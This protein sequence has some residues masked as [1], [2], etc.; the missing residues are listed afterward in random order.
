MK[1]EILYDLGDK[2]ASLSFSNDGKG[3][4]LSIILEDVESYEFGDVA[5]TAGEGPDSFLV[6]SFSCVYS[7]LLKI[8]H[9]KPQTNTLS[10]VAG[11]P[12]NDVG[13]V[14]DTEGQST[15]VMYNKLAFSI[16]DGVALSELV[17]IVLGIPICEGNIE[18]GK[19]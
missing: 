10:F 6:P 19:D 14:Y 13:L 2:S 15:W 18:D 16:D 4:P 17:K 1:L 7:K 8:K 11:N 12:E 9:S 3:N 5:Q